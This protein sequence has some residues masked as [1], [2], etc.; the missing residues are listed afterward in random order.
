MAPNAKSK[1][2]VFMQ[3]TSD[4]RHPSPPVFPILRTLVLDRSKV[5]SLET[6]RRGSCERGRP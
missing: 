1:T 2:H 3:T 5:A 4:L 6:T